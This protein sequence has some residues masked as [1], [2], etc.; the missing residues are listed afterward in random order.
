M[1][2][3]HSMRAAMEAAVQ[4]QFDLLLSD[5]ALPDGSGTDLMMQVRAIRPIPG[6]AMSGFGM[7]ADIDRS[8]QAGF[9]DHLVKPV[10]PEQ[11]EALI[12]RIMEDASSS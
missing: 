10:K 5:I 8:L 4:N 9:V 11:L 1:A 7:Q 3:T 6:I 12:N 2:A